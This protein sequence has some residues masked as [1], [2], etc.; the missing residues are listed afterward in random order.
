MTVLDVAK[1]RADFPILSREINGHP[2]VY[3]DSANTSQKPRQVLEVMREQY[4]WHNANVSRSVHTLGTE[5]TAAYEGARAK[6]AA[7]I[8]ASSPDEIVFTKNSS[9]ATRSWSPRWS[10]TPTSYRGSCSASGPAPRCA[11]SA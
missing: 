1:V 9:E 7:F 2:L 6:V 3:L 4:E 8:G 5:A 11:G 10:T